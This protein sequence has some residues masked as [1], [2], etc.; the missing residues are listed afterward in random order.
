MDTKHTIICFPCNYPTLKN[1]QRQCCMC[2]LFFCEKKE[3]SFTIFEKESTRWIFDI[4]T[5]VYCY[6]CISSFD[7][8]IILAC[9]ECKS[10]TITFHPVFG[11]K[12]NGW[13]E[14]FRYIVVCDNGS[15]TWEKKD[16]RNYKGLCYCGSDC[17]SIHEKRTKIQMLLLL[18][19]TKNTDN[20]ECHL[21]KLPKDIIKYIFSYL[22][23]SMYN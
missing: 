7:G 19:L 20:T 14:R 13:E 4:K 17:Y 11:D 3:C 8:T 2:K 5:T 23:Y 12:L 1:Y 10:K 21:G 18:A 9:H 6:K 16:L 15:D 22:R